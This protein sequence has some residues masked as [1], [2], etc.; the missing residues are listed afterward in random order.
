MGLIEG[1]PGAAV[2]PPQPMVSQI[3][4]A[5]D[6]YAE[7]GGRYEEVIIED[8]GHVPFIE[9]PSAFNEVF[10]RFLGRRRELTSG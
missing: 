4:A 6:R 1:Y 9:Q 7:H 5:L 2:F 8:S 10:H 3:R